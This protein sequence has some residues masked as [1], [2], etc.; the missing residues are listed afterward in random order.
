[1]AGEIGL[2]ERK[3][4]RTRQAISDAAIALFLKSG[5]DAVSVAEIAEAAE[6]SKRT[7]FAYFPTKEDLVLH[8]FAD[9]ETESAWC[10]RERAVR[11]T[12]LAALRARFLTGLAERE[13]ITGL[14]EVPEVRD[15]F[16]MVLETP[17]LAARM[18]QFNAGAERALAEALRET[19][20]VSALTA[21]VAAAQVVAVQWTLAVDNHNRI[22]AGQ[23]ADQIYPIAVE[24][25][26]QAFALLARGLEPE[27]I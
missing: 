24:S 2:R 20:T 11:Q 1:M 15:L 22:V 10:V 23:A 17:A 5:F 25:A 7:L 27:G 9:H 14:C 3:K 16:R 12:P 21:R 18:L 8:R 4:L 26:R 6:V 13:P 19:A